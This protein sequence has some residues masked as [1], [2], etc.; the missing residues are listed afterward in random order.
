GATVYAVWFQ[1]DGQD[2]RMV[3]VLQYDADDRS[4]TFSG[5]TP[6]AA[7]E[8]IVTAEPDSTINAPSDVVI[9]RQEV[10]APN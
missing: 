1:P 2:A 9:I 3:G 6:D 8:V 10:S 7:L 4:G 5:T